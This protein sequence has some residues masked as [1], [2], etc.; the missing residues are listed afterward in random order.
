MLSF[1]RLA[2]WGANLY[3]V[4]ALCSF[5]PANFRLLLGFLNTFSDKG[6]GK[7]EGIEEKKRHLRSDSVE[8]QGS[9]PKA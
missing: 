4:A 5:F 9:K 1:A 8:A 7:G 3:F 6:F 2:A